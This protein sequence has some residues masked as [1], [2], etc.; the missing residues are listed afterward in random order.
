MCN[1]EHL[2][3]LHISENVAVQGILIKY[4]AG[5]EL[6]FK[7]VS[8]F[9]RISSIAPI[10]DQGQSLQSS[11]IPDPKVSFCLHNNSF[12]VGTVTWD[13]LGVPLRL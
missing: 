8:S 12:G 7:A 4:S 9:C 2:G 10:G 13:G 5:N 1:A 3:V 6:H 11:F